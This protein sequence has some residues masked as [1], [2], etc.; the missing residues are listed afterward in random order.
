M[1]KFLFGLALNSLAMAV[2]L[3]TSLTVTI[4]PGFLLLSGAG[5]IIDASNEEEE[6]DQNPREI[7]PYIGIPQNYVR[8]PVA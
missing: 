3:F 8:H 6:V 4:G 5:L 2:M 1:A 7:M